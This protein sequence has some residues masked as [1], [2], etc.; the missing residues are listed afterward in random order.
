MNEKTKH[1]GL[2]RHFI[3]TTGM[4]T[5]SNPL[6]TISEKF[7]GMSDKLSIYNRVGASVLFYFGMGYLFVRGRDMY[8]HLLGVGKDS[9]YKLIHDAAWGAIFG[10]LLNGVITT[11]S[12]LFNEIISP[13]DIQFLDEIV[14]GVKAGAVT[15]SITGGPSGYFIDMFRDLTDVNPAGRLPYRIRS[16]PPKLKK[17]FA[18]GLVGASIGVMS[19]I[20]A[21]APDKDPNTVDPIPQNIEQRIEVSW[22]ELRGFAKQTLVL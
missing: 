22:Y 11:A 13:S 5:S 14:G 21:L 17:G 20:Y 18:A 9:N 3:D 19:L 12:V 1:G 15:G 8:Y 4:L 6:F 7:F 16:L 2:K 10:A